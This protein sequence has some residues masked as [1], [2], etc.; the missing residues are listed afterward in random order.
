[1]LFFSINA[2]DCLL[3]IFVLFCFFFSRAFSVFFFHHL[4]FFFACLRWQ[5]GNSVEAFELTFVDAGLSQQP[6]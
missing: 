6:K 3:V 4:V 1:M 5:I 2:P